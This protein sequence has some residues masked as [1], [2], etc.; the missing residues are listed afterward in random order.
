MNILSRRRRN[1]SMAINAFR[2]A[3]YEASL[4]NG[5]VIAGSSTIPPSVLGDMVC[6]GLAAQDRVEG[7]RTIYKLTSEGNS[8]V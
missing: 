8:F 6:F 4:V 5:D 2:S 7:K 3:G 1:I